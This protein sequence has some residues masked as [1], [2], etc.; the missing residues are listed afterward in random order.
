MTVKVGKCLGEIVVISMTNPGGLFGALTDPNYGKT[1]L[2][3]FFNELNFSYI[4]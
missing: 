2:F 3:R 1:F 4:I